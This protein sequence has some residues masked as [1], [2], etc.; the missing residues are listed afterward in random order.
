MNRRQ[1]LTRLTLMGTGI[2]FSALSPATEL[3]QPRLELVT[4]SDYQWTGV[5]VSKEGRIFVTFPTQTEFP[6]FHVGE[7]KAGVAAPLLDREE[8]R[9]FSNLTGIYLDALDRLWVLDSGKLE[10]RKT[11]TGL[12][13]L[14]CID[15]RR[16]RISRSHVISSGLL[17][18]ES[19]LADLRIDAHRG[20][21]Y[22]S[23]AGA[24]GILVIDLK[25]G[26]QWMGLD[27]KTA[28]TRASGRFIA[29]PHQNYTPDQPHV[30][31]LTFSEDGRELYF[32]PLL[33]TRI[34]SIPLDVI[35]DH[36][37]PMSQ[38][39][40]RIRIL[41]EHIHPSAGMVVRDGV[42]Y[43]GDLQGSRIMTVDIKTRSV[44]HLPLPMPIHWADDFAK[45]S[46]GDIWFTESEVN[47]P[48]EKRRRYRL[49]RLTWQPARLRATSFAERFWRIP[50]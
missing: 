19:F 11:P 40:S 44:A 12:A 45:D 9:S 32:T 1:L 22:L 13:K 48:I 35:S 10:G 46:Q 26:D 31:G 8:N 43:M 3:R 18:A 41:A 25:S 50:R 39:C 30:N 20:M 2:G 16:N 15:I 7:L 4:D 37:M 6:S 34:F 21:A 49:Y 24:G 17:T 42:I 5:A 29:Y 28:Q 47:I 27:R 38:R 23:D 36:K 14:V 33:E